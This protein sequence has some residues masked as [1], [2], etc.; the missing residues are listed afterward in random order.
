MESLNLSSWELTFK[1][2]KFVLID[3]ALT[4]EKSM[5]AFRNL[6]EQ[7]QRMASNSKILETFQSNFNG[8][9]K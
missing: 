4:L 1:N 8:M 3:I 7:S 9:K 5:Q 2:Q 6:F